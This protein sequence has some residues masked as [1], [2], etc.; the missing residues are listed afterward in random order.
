MGVHEYFND[1][2]E[3]LVMALTV[4]EGE[5]SRLDQF[6]LQLRA[7]VGVCQDYTL[8]KLILKT[9]LQSEDTDTYGDLL[10]ETFALLSTDDD[11]ELKSVQYRQGTSGVTVEYDRFVTVEY[12]R[13]VPEE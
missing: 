10:K 11:A 3:K 13:F 8:A 5:E 4:Q 12:D 2:S 6:L 1:A 7:L 9:V